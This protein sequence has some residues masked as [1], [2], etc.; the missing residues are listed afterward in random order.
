MGLYR[1]VDWVVVMVI[2]LRCGYCCRE[3][4]PGN[5]ND[6]LEVSQ[7]CPNLKTRPDGLCSCAIYPN[8]PIQC[9]NERMG[10][11][12]GE[13]CTI[14]LLALES[15]KVPRPTRRCQNCGQPCYN[16]TFCSSECANDAIADLNAFIKRGCTDEV[17]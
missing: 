6:E 9:K 13:P 5:H 16:T 1:P 8:R 12:E 7:P 4:W 3:I 14:G 11:A 17:S 10:A 15:G 2:C